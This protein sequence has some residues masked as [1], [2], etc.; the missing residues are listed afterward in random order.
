[1]SLEYWL[2]GEIPQ[3]VKATVI[4]DVKVLGGKIKQHKKP[5]ILLGSE[6]YRLERVVNSDIV[7]AAVD[8]ANAV[9]ADLTTSNSDIV[10]RLDSMGFKKYRVEFPMKAVQKL[11]KNMDYDL[12][13]FIGFQYHYEWLLLNYLKHYAY[14]HLNTLS[15]EPYGH[16]NATWTMPS[17]PIPLWHKNLLALIE[18]LKT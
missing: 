13:M 16:P 17:L 8:I 2:K 4:T 9:K 12:A 15:L 18:V 11:A 7:A 6:L 3:P 1:M 5:V 10:Q 14:R